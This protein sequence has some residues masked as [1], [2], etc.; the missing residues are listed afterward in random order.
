[1]S[2]TVLVVTEGGRRLAAGTS[3]AA[4]A[5]DTAAGECE[6]TSPS[7]DAILAGWW[8]ST[9]HEDVVGVGVSAQRVHSDPVIIELV[10]RLRVCLAGGR[11]AGRGAPQLGARVRNACNF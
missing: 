4:G 7:D 3:E 10:V 11:L 9:V 1:M 8:A 6:A 2:P 5:C